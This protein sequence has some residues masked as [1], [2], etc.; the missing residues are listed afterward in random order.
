MI[1]GLQA[2]DSFDTCNYL[3]VTYAITPATNSQPS[4]QL[5]TLDTLGSHFCHVFTR[6]HRGT[7]LGP[8]CY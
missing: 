2:V 6:R 8:T 1:N 3:L 4:L 5:P 7:A